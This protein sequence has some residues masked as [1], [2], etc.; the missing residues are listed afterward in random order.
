MAKKPE[1]NN[2]PKKPCGRNA[3]RTLRSGTRV[4]TDIAPGH[5]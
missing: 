3:T 1:P 4:N 2:G 5:V